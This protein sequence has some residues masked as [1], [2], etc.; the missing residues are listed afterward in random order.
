MTILHIEHK[1]RDYNRWKASFDDDPLDRKGSEVRRYRIARAVDNPSYV[2]V[3]LEFDTIAKAEHM[4]ASL[5]DLWPRRMGV[6]IDDPKGRVFDVAE[7]QE[8]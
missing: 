2:M 4:L 8:L 5:Q 6:L 7:T 3:D 1:V